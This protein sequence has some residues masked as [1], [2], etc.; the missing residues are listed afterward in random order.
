MRYC[1]RV[2]RAALRRALQALSFCTL[3]API[4]VLATFAWQRR[5]ITDD[6]FID[7]RVVGNL[8]EGEGPVF[9]LGERVEAY[10][11]PLWVALLA[12]GGLVFRS[13][14]GGPPL[15]WLAL[16]LGLLFTLAGFAAAQA[17]AL[18]LLRNQLS[19]P[20]RGATPKPLRHLLPV[21][22]PPL[23]TL[24]LVP[25][26]AQWDFAT[27]G[28]ET[29]LTTSWLGL[30]FFAVAARPRWLAT[31]VLTGLGAII[32]PDLLIFGI[33]FLIALFLRARRPHPRRLAAPLIAFL[34]LP[35]AYQLFRMGY[36]ASLL[37]NTA[38]AKEAGLV[39]WDQGWIYLKDFAVPYHLWIPLAAVGIWWLGFLSWLA[40]RRR[41]PDLALALMPVLCGLLYAAGVVR[42]GGDFMH[43]RLFLPPLFA[44]TLPVATIGVRSLR[45]AWLP[46]L[47]LLIV[48]PWAIAAAR[49][50]RPPYFAKGN[51]V[52]PQGIADERT[53]YVQFAGYHPHPVTL[54][55]YAA[56]VWP[57]DGH[58]LR[59]AADVAALRGDRA[60]FPTKDWLVERGPHPPPPQLPLAPSN[61]QWLDS[62]IRV[63]AHR[64]NV[65]LTG[66]AAGPTVHLV[67][68]LGL[69]DP[70]ASRLRLERRK[71]PGHEKELP[72][73][74]VL[75]R[76]GSLAL[77]SGSPTDRPISLASQTSAAVDAA[78]RS[79]TCTD[80]DLATLLDAIT[81][82]LT[83]PRFWQ[84]V[85]LSPRLTQLRFA[86]DS[87]RAEVE[88]CAA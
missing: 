50:Y 9:N 85:A 24:V 51:G 32:R 80:S 11:N 87:I 78:H 19:D 88:L 14:D 16:W 86:A 81:Q 48:V 68:H 13:L 25:L 21:F 83:W 2:W 12:L 72:D 55:D 58:A 36:F 56:G 64:N 17:G 74:W 41:W 28:L 54:A 65:G 43:G 47:P 40:Y 39:R 84:N 10:S 79:L 8:L 5:W 70:I 59:A 49:E 75:A 26:S 38:L 53:F 22:A 29:G 3:L 71:R 77:P 42:A 73:E 44:L 31:T 66:Y 4:A 7:L 27:S 23:G 57:R 60:L 15:E 76:F 30:T 35:S 52:G 37:P 1:G 34:F 45:L 18:L 6:A 20:P 67:D 69:A 33:G 61:P 62:R 63:V 82:P 46:V